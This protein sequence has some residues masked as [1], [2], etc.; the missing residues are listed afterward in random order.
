MKLQMSVNRMHKRVEAR[1]AS[2]AEQVEAQ[3]M[4]AI[5][6]VPQVGSQS[7]SWNKVSK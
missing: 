7:P 3:S 2:H 6:A 4:Q 1:A 5:P